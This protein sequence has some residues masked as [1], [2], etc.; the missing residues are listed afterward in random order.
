MDLSSLRT[1]VSD[2]RATAEVRGVRVPGGIVT[3]SGID[4]CDSC[5]RLLEKGQELAGL[6]Q[7]CEQANSFHSSSVKAREAECGTARKR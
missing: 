5:G 6:C 1:P 4:H 7:R 2:A 3:Y